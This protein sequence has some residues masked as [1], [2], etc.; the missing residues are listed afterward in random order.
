[1]IIVLTVCRK[2]LRWVL[3]LFRNLVIAAGKQN[4]RSYRFALVVL[5]GGVKAQAP[6][7]VFRAVPACVVRHRQPVV[8]TPPGFL[9]QLADGEPPITLPLIRQL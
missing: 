8:P 5:A 4:A 6:V 7:E 2:P 1:M 3:R 9:A